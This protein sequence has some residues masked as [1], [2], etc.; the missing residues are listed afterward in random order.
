MSLNRGIFIV[1]YCL[2]LL[3][4]PALLL[5]RRRDTVS[6]FTLV[7]LSAVIPASPFIFLELGPTVQEFISA[8]FVF[9][10]GVR[11]GIGFPIVSLLSGTLSG[12]FFLVLLLLRQNSK[13]SISP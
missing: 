12:L 8:G 13:N 6:M 1:G 11:A 7:L 10:A 3:C 4:V 9:T 5:L 2:A